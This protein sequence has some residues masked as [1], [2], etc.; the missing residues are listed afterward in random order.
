GAVANT[1]GGSA[2]G[3]F[4]V[5]S[6]NGGVGVAISN[7]GSSGNVVLGNLI[8]TNVTGLAK[9]GNNSGVILAA[10]ATAN[11]IGGTTAAAANV[12]SGNSVIGLDLDGIATTGNVVLGNFI[13]TDVHGT[14]G[15]GNT[16]TG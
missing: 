13:G 15:L 1:I 3:A 16:S 5:I 8:G 6:G 2:A 11:T 12:I 10:G 9:L 4:N 7:S 14:A